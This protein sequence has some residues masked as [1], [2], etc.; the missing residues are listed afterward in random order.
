MSSAAISAAVAARYYHHYEI[1]NGI[2]ML[3][4]TLS[5]PTYS[6]YSPRSI[7]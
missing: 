2:T 4:V 6:L 7:M 5:G 3:S 1:T